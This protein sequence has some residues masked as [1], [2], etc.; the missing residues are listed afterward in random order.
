MNTRQIQPKSVWFNNGEKSATIL[1]LSEFYGY[2]FDDGGGVIRYKLIGME[3]PGE[4]TT[5][6]GTIILPEVAIDYYIGTLPIPSS[7][8]TQWGSSDSIIWDYV[9]QALNIQY[10]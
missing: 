5:E 1:A 7:I 3:S 4:S 2:H 6:D 10:I 8:V 9:A